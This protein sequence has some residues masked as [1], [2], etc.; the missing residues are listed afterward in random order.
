MTLTSTRGPGGGAAP[1]PRFLSVARVRKAHG[2]RGDLAIHLLVDRLEDLGQAKTV[3]LGET[4]TAYPLER[5]WRHRQGAL[6]KLAGCDD[7]TQAEALQGQWVYIKLEDAP[8]LEPNEYYCRQLLGLN[9]VTLEGEALG[10]LDEIL[11]TGAND[12]YVVRGPRGEVLL[13]A[14]LEVIRQVDLERGVMTVQL[15]PGLLSRN[16]KST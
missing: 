14:R 1:E 12:V 13:P 11:E 6:L 15:L 10:V 3:Y 5:V 2:L 9:V 8:P 4:F 16:S 7:R